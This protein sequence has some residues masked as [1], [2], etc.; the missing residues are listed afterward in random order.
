MSKS[1]ISSFR[2]CAALIGFVLFCSTAAVAQLL[3]GAGD[4]IKPS[5][6]GGSTTLAFDTT[7][8]TNSGNFTASVGSLT[9]SHTV[10][11]GSVGNP[12]LYVAVITYSASLVTTNTVT[13]NGSSCAKIDAQTDNI[14]GNNQE[15]THWSCAAPTQGAHDIVATFSATADF[16]L[17]MAESLTG[18]AQSSPIDSHTTAQDNA[19][20]N[21]S[22]TISTTVVASN[23]WLVGFVFA[24]PQ[25]GTPT[26]I[27]G[28][29]TTI[30]RAGVTSVGIGDSNGTVGTG[31]QSLV[32]QSSDNSGLKFAGVTIASIKHGP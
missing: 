16:S 19:G 4:G 26:I 32:F 3:L 24:R 23:A 29:G 14:E 12:F 25:F 27:A 17:G 5:A 21:P 20:T 7:S 30:R 10:D 1:G 31:S 8:G 28:A 15:T 9:W 18:A 22:I 6:A 2:A 13:F 11:N